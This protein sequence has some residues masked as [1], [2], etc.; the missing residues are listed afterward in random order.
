LWWGG[1]RKLKKSICSNSTCCEV[2][3]DNWVFM[4][5]KEQCYRQQDINYQEASKYWSIE[6]EGNKYLCDVGVKN[7]IYNAYDNLEKYNDFYNECL[8]LKEYTKDYQVKATCES[9]KSDRDDA[10]DTFWK[11]IERNCKKN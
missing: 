6:V 11:L 9:A 5:S 2:S 8:Y 1:T 4:E 7:E 10:D 3:K